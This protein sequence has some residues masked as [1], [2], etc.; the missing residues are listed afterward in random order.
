MPV[1]I[2]I[3][4]DVV[5]AYLSGEID[6]HNAAKVRETIDMA[7]TQQQAKMLRLDFRDVEFMDS[8]GIGLVLGRYRLM[9]DLEGKLMI[10]NL[11]VHLKKVMRLAGIDNLGVVD[12]G[13]RAG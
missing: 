10:L 1:R 8:S 12:K 11:P 6:H 2:E 7:A 5:S 3:N 4:E 9:Q 13:G